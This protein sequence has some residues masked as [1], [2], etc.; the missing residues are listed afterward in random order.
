M[1]KE[2]R[3]WREWKRWTG[4]KRTGRQSVKGGGG[5]EIPRKGEI[6][7]RVREGQEKRKEGKGKA[8]EE[9]KADGS[10][11]FLRG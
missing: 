9:R 3:T 6:K 10:E 7:R 2:K 8:G 4:G 5:R 1:G 11:A